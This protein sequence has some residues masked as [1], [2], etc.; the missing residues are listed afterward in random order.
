MGCNEKGSAPQTL[1]AAVTENSATLPNISISNPNDNIK[2]KQSEIINR[3]NDM[4]KAE[5]TTIATTQ[6]ALDDFAIQITRASENGNLVVVNKN[7]AVQMLTAIGV[8]PAEASNILNLAKDS[9]ANLNEDVKYSTSAYKSSSTNQLLS[10]D[11]KEF[12]QPTPEATFD[13]GA[14]K[15]IIFPVSQNVKPFSL[16]NEGQQRQRFAKKAETS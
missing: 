16:S 3:I 5:T 4:K 15:G 7:K 9:I 11:S 8:Q 13:N 1:L 2:Q 6:N 12:P 10:I 14:T